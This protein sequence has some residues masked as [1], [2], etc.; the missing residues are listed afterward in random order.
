MSSEA[1][2]IPVLI[3][4]HR[5]LFDHFHANDANGRGPG[6]GKLDFVPIFQALK[7]IDYRGWIS[8]EV[9][10]DKP[11]PE[12]TARESIAYM[13]KCWAKAEGKRR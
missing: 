2:P 9:F 6:F 4:R 10:D 5:G 8:V 1:S 3:R 12:Q 13:R 7:E 11:T